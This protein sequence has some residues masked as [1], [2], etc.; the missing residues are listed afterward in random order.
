M[1]EYQGQNES[2]IKN[3]KNDLYSRDREISELKTELEKWSTRA[4]D[5][6]NSEVPRLLEE[7][8]K[9]KELHKQ[10]LDVIDFKSDE[11]SASKNR[12]KE[13]EEGLTEMRIKAMELMDHCLENKYLDDEDETEGQVEFNVACSKS[14]DL[15]TKK[16]G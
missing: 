10:A 1:E 16:Q 4:N 5:L 14:L 6:V 3:L 9:Y 2:K 7:R 8:D 12:I 15:L 11:L 13:L